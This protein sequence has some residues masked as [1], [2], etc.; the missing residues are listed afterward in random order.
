MTQVPLGGVGVGCGFAPVNNEYSKRFGDP[1]PMLV[2]L[3][4][5]AV[6]VM[7]LATVAGEAVGLPSR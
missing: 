7:A 6:L 3:P 1:V 2:N 4:E 5:E